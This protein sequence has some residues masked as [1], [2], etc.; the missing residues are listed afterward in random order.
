MLLDHSAGAIRALGIDRSFISLEWYTSGLKR[1]SSA[2]Q[3]LIHNK[4]IVPF[5]SLKSSIENT[6]NSQ[7]MLLTVPP[8]TSPT[9]DTLST[10]SPGAKTSSSLLPSPAPQQVLVPLPTP[11][12]G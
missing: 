9:P 4:S 2:G 8:N 11:T 7:I 3:V 6:H 1:N 12:S 10:N 5:V